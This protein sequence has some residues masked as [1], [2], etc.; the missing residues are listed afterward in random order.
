MSEM[1]MFSGLEAQGEIN[2]MLDELFGDEEAFS[3]DA[4]R[5]EHYALQRERLLLGVQGV[6]H[7]RVVQGGA[8]KSS[9]R[10]L[11]MFYDEGA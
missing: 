3:N 8:Q 11:P 1:L 5:G 6:E 7:L 4:G 9:P 10:V 2:G